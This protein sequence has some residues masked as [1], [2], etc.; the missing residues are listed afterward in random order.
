MEGVA[1]AGGRSEAAR[2]TLLTE[3]SVGLTAPRVGELQVW[4]QRRSAS[5]DD[6]GLGHALQGN[7]VARSHFQLLIESLPLAA[8]EE[9]SEGG[10]CRCCC[11]CLSI[12]CSYSSFGANDMG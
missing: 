5:D 4:I 7:P 9:V 3:H 8:T 10:C 2:L 11:C 12:V 1:A 6:R